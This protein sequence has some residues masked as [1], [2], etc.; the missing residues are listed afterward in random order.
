[1]SSIFKKRYMEMG[2]ELEFIKL[3][4]CIRTN[5][6]KISSEKLK[7]RLEKRGVV[8]EKVPFLKDSFYIKKSKFNVVS[9]PE[10]LLGLFY[11][12]E[13]AAQIPA[14]VLKPKGLVLDACAAPGGKT[15]QLSNYCDVIAVE[16][17]RDRLE[18]L[19]NNLERL[20]IKNCIAYLM[21]FRS[22]TK[23]F[24]YI[25]LDAPCSGN[26]MLEKDWLR[27]SNLKRINERAE[28]QKEL[29]AHAIALLN[30]EGV[31][32]YSTCSLEPEEDEFV[33]QY[34]LDNFDVKLEKVQTIGDDGLTEIFGRKLDKN[35]KYCKRFWPHKTNTIGFFIARLRKC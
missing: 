12:Q 16:N 35:M 26:F 33:I 19:E 8:L 11:I 23:T 34:A 4:R 13:A 31:L 6:Q 5:T 32:V 15:T 22:V 24:N 25:L 28:L 20:G 21:D 10:Y 9:S 14:E 18:S 2:E 17:Q 27:K 7:E 1:M 30:K 29:I 3:S